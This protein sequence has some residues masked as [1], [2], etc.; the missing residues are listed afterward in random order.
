MQGLASRKNHRNSRNP[1]NDNRRAMQGPA[2]LG[3][4][5]LSHVSAARV[6][7]RMPIGFVKRVTPNLRETGGCPHVPGQIGFPVML[8]GGFA[9]GAGGSG[10][11]ES[12]ADLD[13]ALRRICANGEECFRMPRKM[14]R[15]TLETPCRS[16]LCRKQARG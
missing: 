2:W 11:V 1:R 16:L 7:A 6:T 10:I 14:A 9:L 3:L 4:S 12:E 8:R 13:H 15:Q 5:H